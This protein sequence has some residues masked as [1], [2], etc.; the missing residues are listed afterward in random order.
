MLGIHNTCTDQVFYSQGWVLLIMHRGS[1]HADAMFS[2]MFKCSDTF[3]WRLTTGI[4]PWRVAEEIEVLCDILG[5]RGRC[6]HKGD[7]RFLCKTNCCGCNKVSLIVCLRCS[8]LACCSACADYARSVSL[9]WLQ[10]GLALSTYMRWLQC[11]DAKLLV[12]T[13]FLTL[14]KD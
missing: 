5:L 10:T 12:Y 8:P 1:Q 4:V 3:S 7:H 11:K 6:V 9:A 2:S 13:V 14:S